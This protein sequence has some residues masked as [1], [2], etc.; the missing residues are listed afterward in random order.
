MQEIMFSV[1]VI[2]Y[3]QEEYIAQTLDSILNQEHD[4]RYEI[5]IGEDCSTDNTKKIIEEYVSQYPEIIKPLY[6]NPNKG[7]INNYFNVINH[8]QG[9]YIMECAG[10][11]YWLPGKVK[12][13]IEYME[14][15]PDV[16]MCYGK[17]KFWSENKQKYEKKLFGSDIECFEK[18]LT[19][20]NKVPAL[21]VCLRKKL[22]ERYVNEIQPQEKNW[23]MEDY[24][25]WLWFSHECKVK[26]FNEV[27]AVYRALENSA[28]HSVDVEKQFRFEK[29]TEE[30]KEFYSKIYSIR[31]E[32]FADEIIYFRLYVNLLTKEY[33][34][35]IAK[36]MRLFFKR[37]K[38]RSLKTCMLF[39][40]S[41]SKVTWHA[42]KKIRGV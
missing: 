38:K 11:D 20:G 6:N 1:V 18:L 39:F 40:S 32:A 4:Y 15:H 22:V 35:E 16:G 12:T 23:L 21:T 42:L 24:P 27:T 7:L 14:N 41:Y 28:S 13:Q 26:F 36:K 2:T 17:A 34:N 9:K 31:Y 33:N 10:D 8:C 19:T 37:I 30:I 3:N 25:M 29:N 5:V